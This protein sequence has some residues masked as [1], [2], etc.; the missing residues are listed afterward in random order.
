[1]DRHQLTQN[2]RNYLMGERRMDLVG[3]CP[4]E[5][6][7]EEPEGRRPTDLLG[8]CRSV[9]VFGRM[10]VVEDGEEELKRE[11]SA[12][13]CRTFTDDEAFLQNERRNALPRACFMELTIEHMTGK[14]VN[15]S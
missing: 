11:I 4:A 10:R 1:M 8:C 14:L 15:E 6:L 2:V 3:F 12:G 7:A 13:L 5:A 9:I